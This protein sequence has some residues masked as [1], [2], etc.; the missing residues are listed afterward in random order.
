MTCVIAV[1]QDDVGE[2]A[3]G[4]QILVIK[5]VRWF[6]DGGELHLLL[7]LGARK[8][9]QLRRERALESRAGFAARNVGAQVGVVIEDPGFLRPEQH[10]DQKGRTFAHRPMHPCASGMR[11]RCHNVDQ[12]Q[13]WIPLIF[14]APKR[15]PPAGTEI[16]KAQ[17]GTVRRQT[18]LVLKQAAR[19]GC[20]MR[21]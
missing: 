7:P 12:V 16:F 11:Q 20:V 19:P 18:L 9:S 10:S 17:D 5:R 14:C 13:V 8:G 3:R 15:E 2:F 6:A 1:G 4:I 21:K